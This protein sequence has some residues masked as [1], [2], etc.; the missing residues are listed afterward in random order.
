MNLFR[1]TANFESEKSCRLHFKEERDKI[2]VEC[3]C[4]SKQHFWIKSRWSYD[5][6]KCRSR[7][8]LRIGTIMQSSNLSFIV[9]T[10]L[11]FING[12]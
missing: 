7:I 4:E 5:C 10:K 3:K 8:L 1:F 9:C 6:K 11:C 12:N 2:G